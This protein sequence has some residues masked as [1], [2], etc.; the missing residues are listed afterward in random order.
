MTRRTTD[1]KQRAKAA[2]EGLA[3]DDDGLECGL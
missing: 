2:R 3:G 1:P